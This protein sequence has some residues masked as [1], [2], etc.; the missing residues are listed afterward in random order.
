MWLM[1]P[2]KNNKQYIRSLQIY[3]NPSSTYMS[4]KALVNVDTAKGT[5]QK[6]CG[7][8]S[9]HS[10]VLVNSVYH[11]L[12]FLWLFLVVLFRKSS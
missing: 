10:T 4:K 5:S 1:T 3:L 2:V 6:V 7:F 9:C 11:F 8:R 12:T